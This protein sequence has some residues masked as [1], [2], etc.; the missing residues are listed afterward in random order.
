MFNNFKVGTKLL[1]AFI[2]IALISAIV[3]TVGVRKIHEVDDADTALYEKMAVP[4]AG[5]A[6][7]SI[8]FQEVG[9]DL[10][11]LVEAKEDKE[12][13]AAMESISKL[14]QEIRSRVEKLEKSISSEEAR[15]L[16][17]DFKEARKVYG[18]DIDKVQELVKSG[19][20]DEALALLQGDLRKAAAHEMHTI[21]MII[22]SLEKQA[23]LTSDHNTAT[24]NSAS[25][26]MIILVVA[27]ALTAFG[28]GIFMTRMITSPL[29]EAVSVA[30]A[31]GA[32]DLT[33]DIKVNSSDETGEL[34]AALMKMTAN[35]RTIIGQVADTSTQVAS[36]SNQLH[37]T[38]DQIATGAEEVASQA[39]T[40]ATAGEEMSATSSDIAQ[41][42]QMAAEGA[43]QASETA[44]N[45]AA[46]VERTVRVMGQIADKVQESSRTVENLGAR[47]DQI[48]AIIGTIEDIA[49]QTNLLALNAAIEAA[50]AGEQGRGFA[51]VADEVRA[52][53]ERT[54]R[55]TREIGEMIKAIQ[56]ETRGAVT[57]MEEG[58]KQVEAG[59]AEAA[60]SGAA[61]QEILEQINN[62]AM[63][64]HQ[65]ATAAEEQTATT[66]EISCNI[67]QITQVVQQTSQGA[68]ESAGAAA[69]LHANSEEL[70][71]LVR[72]FRL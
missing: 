3:G 22:D 44:Q 38:S 12:R 45:G 13:Q 72:Q 26:L 60:K 53:A 7:I 47:S 15:K 37:A 43:R 25:T 31:I 32:G 42:C 14:R 11:N 30:N 33:V 41:N 21:D 54:T 1:S 64:I 59:T 10:R 40:V 52:L 58:V 48:G 55:A 5:L 20:G 28:C 68:H 46:V 24:A 23:K 27:G 56:S 49:D 19:K 29:Q 51:V 39:G 63:Q 34:M 8:H 50:R 4:L 35:L 36:A 69:Q 61:L 62:V 57:A 2:L 17:T 65:V 66:S 71:R 18:G 6:Q 9:V 70:Q 16:L 67:V